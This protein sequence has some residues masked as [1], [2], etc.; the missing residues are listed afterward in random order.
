[1]DASSSSPVVGIQRYA[2]GFAQIGADE[3]PPLGGVRRR[4]GDGLV[5]GVGPVEVVLEPVQGQTHRGVK[6]RIQQ[7]HLLGGVAGLV[8]EGTAG[9]RGGGHGNLSLLDSVPGK[10]EGIDI[11]ILQTCI[12]MPHRQGVKAP[13]PPIHLDYPSIQRINQ[14]M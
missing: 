3:D 9:G 11:C 13:H 6:V 7:R 10:G 1:M 14:N 12:V 8:D 2:A 5:P 4:H